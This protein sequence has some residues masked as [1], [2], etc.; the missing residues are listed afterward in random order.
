MRLL[1]SIIVLTSFTLNS[2]AQQAC[3]LTNAKLTDL[4][5]AASR[6]AKTITLSAECKAFETNVNQANAQLK[7]VANKIANLGD[8][9]DQ[10]N[11]P[12]M[13]DTA[14]QAITHLDTVSTLF[15]DQ[16]CGQQLV[17]FLDYAS[18]FVDVAT[19]MVPFLALYGGPAA[20]P[21]VLGPAI[22][23]AAA[24]ALIAF[25]KNKSINMRDA[26]QS[27]SF[28]KNSCAFYNLNQIKESI[29]DLEIRQSPKIETTL[30]ETKQE[31]ANLIKHAPKEP[32]LDIVSL[33]QQQE[34]DQQK[35]KFLADQLKVDAQEGCHYIN[36]FANQTDPKQGAGSL[37]DRVWSNYEATLIDTP[38]RL[39]LERKFFIEDLNP[40]VAAGVDTGKC[41]RWLTKMNAMLDAGLVVLRKAMNDDTEMKNYQVF[42]DEKTRLQD[43]IKLQEAQLKFFH[44]LMGTGFSIE[45]SEIIRSHGQVQDSIFE[46]YRWLRTLKMKGLAE[47]WLIVKSEDAEMELSAFNIRKKEIEDRIRNLE[48]KMGAPFTR[49]NV[50][51]FAARFFSAHNREHPEVYKSVVV[52][53]CNQLRRTWASWHNGFIHA[54]AGRDYCIVFDRVINRMDYPQVQHLCF[55]TTTRRGRP[56]QSLKNQVHQLREKKSEADQIAARIQELRC[57][58]G[59]ELTQDLLKLPLN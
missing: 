38:F 42:L 35:L 58:A 46:S 52:D 44:E 56:V 48:R 37:V 47:A 20:A 14:L 50:Q 9:K 29:D 49:D 31:L 34:R 4:R 30:I 53:V 13:K 54:K 51:E 22:G 11:R 59:D 2:Y 3:P 28:L 25:F 1:L 16:K 40:S 6:L 23:G 8:N 33:L 32:R 5:Q 19:G 36:A 45:Y 24:K 39:D 7:D 26:D 57:R 18:V 27:N 10:T 21:W 12:D 15:K 17:S 55:G 41:N 43:S